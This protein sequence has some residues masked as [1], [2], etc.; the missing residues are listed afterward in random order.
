M[1]LHYQ[2]GTRHV[3]CLTGS[4]QLT[5]LHC[6]VYFLSVKSICGVNSWPTVVYRHKIVLFLYSVQ[7]QEL[8]MHEHVGKTGSAILR[9]TNLCNT[10]F[11]N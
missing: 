2:D 8:L 3:C 7:Y 6:F 11:G 10:D 5:L 4:L 9:K 1:A